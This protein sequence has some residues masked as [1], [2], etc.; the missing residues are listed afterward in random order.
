MMKHQVR[1]AGQA[2]AYLTDC[3]MATVADLAMKKSRSKSEY[4]RQIGIAQQ[5]VDW[6]R[7]FKI[8]ST[9]TRVADLNG[10]TVEQ[11]AMQ[12]EPN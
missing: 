5:G 3:T 11:W 1:N 8:D 2:L 4:K 7:D 12:Y 9:S 6:L 10:M